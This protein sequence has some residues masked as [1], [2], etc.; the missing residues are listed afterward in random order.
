MLCFTGSPCVG[1]GSEPVC[2]VLPGVLVFFL[3]EVNQ[4]SMYCLES[5]HGGGGGG[6]GTNIY[7]L[8]VGLACVWG[9]IIWSVVRIHT[10]SGTSM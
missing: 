1:G 10:C 5:F 2:Y 7:V 8:L 6:G 3:W 4:C 9:T